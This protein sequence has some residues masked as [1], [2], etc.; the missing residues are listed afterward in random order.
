MIPPKQRI[1][2]R[3]LNIDTH[4]RWAKQVLAYFKKG[5]FSQI[6]TEFIWDKKTLLV[7]QEFLSSS[8]LSALS[9][10]EERTYPDL[11]SFS[12]KISQ[13][14]GGTLFKRKGYLICQ[15]ASVGRRQFVDKLG[16]LIDYQSDITEYSQMVNLAH[17]AQKQ[18]KQ[19]GLN[20]DSEKNFIKNTNHLILSARGQ[21]FKEQIKVYLSNEGQQI[22]D[23][24]TLL[25]TSD[26]IESIL[27]KYKYFSN[28]RPLKE[29]G[30]ILLT[31]PLFTTEISSNL[32]KEAMEST[33]T[34][35]VQKWTQKV[36]G[37][38]MLSKRRAISTIENSPQLN[39][40]DHLFNKPLFFEL[41]QIV[42]ND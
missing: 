36:F 41:S 20:Q 42:M 28:E 38:S 8:T 17:T 11:T 21:R 31:I 30:Q 26:L 13:H 37:Q 29:I 12:K 9:T 10:L 1:K 5:D 24:Q 40:T 34:K 23:K 16:W 14:I 3:Y 18:V 19:N 27:G 25:A 33:R 6:S 2:S 7:L 35:D 15:A 39:T 32:V 4:L 22:P